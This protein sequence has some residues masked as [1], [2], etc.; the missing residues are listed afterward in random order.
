[1]KVGCFNFNTIHILLYNQVNH[2]YLR[3]NCCVVQ[4]VL[5]VLIERSIKIEGTFWLD[6]KVWQE[7]Q[8]LKIYESL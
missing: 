1:M 4:Y 7:S 8:H 3:I 5:G 6:S 2:K